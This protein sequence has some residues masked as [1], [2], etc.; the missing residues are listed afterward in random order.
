MVTSLSKEAWPAQELYEQLY[1]AR[2]EMENRVKEQQLYLFA[3]RT[4]STMMRSNQ[5]RLWFSAVA[6]LLMNEL[7]KV[8]LADTEL[9]N[10][11]C[12]TIR[13]KILKVG[14]RVTVSVRRLVAHMPTGYPYQ[15]LFRAALSN[16]QAAFP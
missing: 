6:Y 10:A 3:D 2:G 4:S 16:I 12:D 7:R 15:R 9:A 1:C 14:A 13:L 11:Q 8:G 5:I